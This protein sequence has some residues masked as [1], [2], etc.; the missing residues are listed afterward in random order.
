[1]HDVLASAELR[2]EGDCRIVTVVGL[3]ED[4]VRASL[5]CQRPD[6][7]DQCSRNAAPS[8][9][10]GYGKVVDVNFTPRPLELGKDVAGKTTDDFLSGG[11][12]VPPV[13]SA[14]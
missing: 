5:L 6:F 2:V 8:M 10:L 12:L 11:A 14:A 1:M 7:L 4:H 13:P 3:D 9:R